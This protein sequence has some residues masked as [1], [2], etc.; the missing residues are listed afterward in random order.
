MGAVPSSYTA[1]A[2]LWRVERALNKLYDDATMQSTAQEERCEVYAPK[3]IAFDRLE[4]SE[5]TFFRFIWKPRKA[6]EAP[7]HISTYDYEKL[8][9]EASRTSSIKALFAS[10]YVQEDPYTEHAFHG[11]VNEAKVSTG[12]YHNGHG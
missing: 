7:E 11:L 8:T 2:G 1:W 10:L 12:R 5:L 3:N 9:P 4:C 6:H